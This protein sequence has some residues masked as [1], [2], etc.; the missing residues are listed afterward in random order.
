MK[1]NLILVYENIY[2][3]KLPITTNAIHPFTVSST[4]NDIKHV[5]GG[6]LIISFINKK[7]YKFSGA[8]RYMQITIKESL[9]DSPLRLMTMVT[10]GAISHKTITGLV[11]LLNK[12]YIKGLLEILRNTK[13]F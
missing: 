4:I 3:N 7:A 1:K 6:D 5:Y 11:N 2:G 10:R 9:N 8:D 12:H 13:R